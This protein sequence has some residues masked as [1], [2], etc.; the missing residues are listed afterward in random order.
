[1]GSGVPELSLLEF[2]LIVLRGIVVARII[3]VIIVIIVRMV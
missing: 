1:M 2:D 3:A